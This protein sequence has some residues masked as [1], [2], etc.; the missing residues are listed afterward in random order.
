MTAPESFDPALAPHARAGAA[1]AKPDA[2]V[3][4]LGQT[5]H[6]LQLRHVL[7]G[8]DPTTAK[9]G[10]GRRAHHEH[11][12][13]PVQDRPAPNPHA[14]PG[15]RRANNDLELRV[16][17]ELGKP[18]AHRAWMVG[19]T[20]ATLQRSIQRQ[21]FKPHGH[22]VGRSWAKKQ[23]RRKSA[24]AHQATLLSSRCLACAGPF[25][26]SRLRAV[27]VS[28]LTVDP[29]PSPANRISAAE[30]G[31]R[32][33]ARGQAHS[34]TLVR[35]SRLWKSRSVLECGCPLPLLTQSA[36]AAER[37]RFVRMSKSK[38][39]FSLLT[40]FRRSPSRLARRKHPHHRPRPRRRNLETGEHA[41]RPR[42]PS[43]WPN[44][45]GD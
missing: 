27:P 42:Q 9:A 13:R 34:K 37:G 17:R 21:V 41:Q 45:G 11:A 38:C 8:P 4:A 36:A 31:R 22:R 32:Q 35:L 29:S 5:K 30:R 15:W 28:I 33:N 24:H 40:L 20:V 6:G 18:Q 16:G 12:P 14:W 1:G 7:P 25:W 39:R 10:L 19:R 44:P 43:L 26:H 3:M 23:Q 2:G